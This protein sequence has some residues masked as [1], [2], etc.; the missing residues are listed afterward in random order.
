MWNWMAD[1]TSSNPDR[2]ASCRQALRQ[3]NQARKNAKSWLPENL[4]LRCMAYRQKPKVY[5]AECIDLDILVKGDF[6]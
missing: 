6:H 4:V 3:K 5:S 1:L 2:G